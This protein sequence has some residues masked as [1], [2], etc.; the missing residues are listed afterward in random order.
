[1]VNL[2]SKLFTTTP[3]KVAGKL[4]PLAD[5]TAKLEAQV[6][7]LSDEDLRAKTAEFRKHYRD[8]EDLDDLLPE[9]FACVREASRRTTGM[10]HYDVQV[11]GGSV[12]H[13]GNIAEMKTGEGKTLVAT[14]PLFLNA[15]PGEGAHLVTVND[16][17]ARR[18][19]QW[20]GPVYHALGMTVGCLQ[21]EASYVYDPTYTSGTPAMSHL[22]PVTR[23]EAYAADIT[24]GTNHEFGFDY[25]RDNMVVDANQ[26]VQRGLAY[27]IVDE[28]D[29]ILIDE[30]RTPLIISGPAQESTQVYATVAGL[31]PR[32][33]LG[34]DFET[35]EKTRGV[36]LLEPGIDK[37]E[38]WLRVPNLYAPE[39]V[40]LVHHIEN[41]LKAQV[42]YRKD[43]EYVVQN[44]EVIIVDEF[45]GRLM[46]GRRWS[47][48]LHQA[49]EA[50]EGL[51][52]QQE[53]ITYATITLQNYFRMYKKL[54]GMTGTGLTEA[55][56]FQKI[57]GLDVMPVPTHRPMIRTD[58]PDYIFV[59]E[60]GK[61]KAIARDIKAEHDKGRPM[62]IGTTSIEKSEMLSAMLRREGITCE[63]LN[64]KQHEREAQVVA[65]AGRIGA[66]TVATNMAGRGTDIILGGNT[67]SLIADELRKHGETTEDA[68]PDLLQKARDEVMARWKEEHDKVVAMGGLFVLGTERHEA[69]RIDNQL[70]GRA[71]RQGDPGTSRFYV[72]LDDDLMRRFGGE[73]V[74]GIMSWA[75]IK[76]DEAIENSMVSKAMEN[77][78]QK[79][80]AQNFEIRRYLVAYDD[81]VNKHRDV[82]YSER[83]K[84]LSGAD[85]KANIL[86]MLEKELRAVMAAKLAGRDADEWDVEGLAAELKAIFPLPDHLQADKLETMAKEEIESAVLEHAHTLYEEREQLFTPQNMRLME[87]LVMLRI[88][89]THWVMHLTTME[90]LRQS[91]GMQGVGQ[92]DPLVSYRTE[93]HQSFESLLTN[94]QRD[95]ARTIFQTAITVQQ[96]EAPKQPTGNGKA[97]GT[98]R[99]QAHQPEAPKA[100]PSQPAPQA[101]QAPRANGPSPRPI[102]T[103][104]QSPMTRVVGPDRNRQP[105]AAGAPK[106]G[107]NDPC[108][109]GSG[110]KY[111]KCHGAGGA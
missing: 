91:V 93:G 34:E 95:I 23:R 51:K 36:T 48:G 60:K 32:L 82:I 111:K 14:L 61:W 45:T 18:D 2:L 52:V 84:I 103:T 65:Q 30:A 26:R 86:E 68:E 6:K 71:G 55:E 27:A 33:K 80:E 43:R 7:A 72:A 4:K 70:R 99:Q 87:R 19:T 28:V 47:D 76:E 9:A 107:R 57:Y 110:K 13:Q 64:A 15:I 90:G 42:H 3:D 50:K 37:M 73:R 10:R 85:L 88:I 67:D 1:M 31:V 94:I 17:L 29:Y 108:P 12:L 63:V 41:A 77:A 74:K 109:C 8:G 102:S 106:V 69:R 16:Y 25:L 44:G 39:N 89:D 97:S 5:A 24:Y 22:R 35:D 92:R 75:G 59:D 11:M 104:P 98:P 38:A 62:L 54:A 101:A 66:V 105:V 96:G 20:M 21:H 78:Q 40:L 58:H 53:T 81:V 79:V 83:N 56:E 49:V 100:A 46:A